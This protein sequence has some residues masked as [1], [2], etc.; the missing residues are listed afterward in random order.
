MHDAA[1]KK[2]TRTSKRDKKQPD[3]LTYYCELTRAQESSPDESELAFATMEVSE[4]DPKTLREVLSKPD[5][6]GW[7]A[8]VSKELKSLQDNETRE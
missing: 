2:E 8:A 4:W 3:R 5:R 6:D 7:Q 1:E